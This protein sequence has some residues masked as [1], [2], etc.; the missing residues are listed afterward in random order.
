MQ[1]RIH[2]LQNEFSEDAKFTTRADQ[3]LLVR[4]GSSARAHPAVSHAV[5]LA[6]G[7][8]LAE[9][10]ILPHDPLRRAVLRGRRGDGTQV[11]GRRGGILTTAVCRRREQCQI[12]IRFCPNWLKCESPRAARKNNIGDGAENVW[13]RSRHASP[14]AVHRC[15]TARARHD[16][17][18][19]QGELWIGASRVGAQEEDIG[20]SR[21]GIRGKARPQIG[22]Q[23]CIVLNDERDAQAALPRVHMRN[24]VLEREGERAI[25]KPCQT[26]PRPFGAC[27][28]RMHT[29]VLLGAEMRYNIGIRAEHEGHVVSAD[30]CKL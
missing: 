6:V 4:L 24:A 20:I 11:H 29:M 22:R 3:L 19:G 26:W 2:D 5:R 1:S 18:L 13:L 16:R 12:Y 23:D 27:V 17:A 28:G 10:L 9:R 7:E 21:D 8:L 14:A 25:G 30:L 15:I